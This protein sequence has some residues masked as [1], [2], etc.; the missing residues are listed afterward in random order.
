MFILLRDECINL[1]NCNNFL[2]KQA[3]LFEKNFEILRDV[4][5]LLAATSNINAIANLILDLAVN[6]TNAGKGS[7]MLVTDQG[8]LHILAARGINM[9]ILNSYRARLGDG[10]AGTVAQNRIPVL[11]EDIQVNDN[12]NSKKKGGYKSHSFI[13]C[14]ILR[15]NKVL[16]LFNVS[17]KQNNAPFTVD[18]FEL[19]KII[20]NQAAMSLENAF[21]LDRLQTK[22]ADLEEMN[23]KLI[24]TDALKTNFLV[25][26]SHE[27]RSPLNSINGAIYYLRSYYQTAESPPGDFYDIISDES[28]K[29]I[30]SVGNLLDCPGLE[31]ET[32]LT[33]KSVLDLPAMVSEVVNSTSLKE[34]L[35]KKNIGLEIDVQA[36]ISNIIGDKIKIVQFFTGMMD[37][38]SRYLEQD[39]FIRVT[40]GE[41]DF[42]KVNI[43]MSGRLPEMLIPNI[44]NWRYMFE[45]DKSEAAIKLYLALKIAEMHG[46]AIAEEN[47]E[48]AYS[49]TITMPQSARQKSEAVIDTAMGMF[50]DFI[51][52]LLGVDTCSIMLIDELAGDLVI[53][54]ARGLDDDI[55]KLTRLK[56]G[57][58][59]AGWVALQGEPLLVEDIENDSRFSGMSIHKYNTRSLLSIPLKINGRVIG[60]INLNNKRTAETFTSLDLSILSTLSD[61]ISHFIERLYSG[62]YRETEIQELVTSFNDLLPAV[63]KYLKKG[64]AFPDL[65]V[66][67]MNVLGAAEE[68]KRLALYAS[69]IYD[70]GLTVNE[71]LIEKKELSPPEMSVL[72]VHPHTSVDLIDDF[73][74]SEDVKEAIL[75]HH[76]KYDGTGYPG[77]LS[78]EEIPFISRVLSVV[79]AFCS[80]ITD[81]PYR[82]A[83]SKHTALQEIKRGAGSKYDPTV[84]KALDEVLQ[85]V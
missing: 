54:K 72:R 50:I 2:M 29:L 6:H 84:V 26:V 19:L 81:R 48:D 62:N 80:M 37:G 38:L 52:E 11:I 39:D 83:L 36:E 70:L 32:R 31:E 35:R 10:I 7:V 25:R 61:R 78:K 42:V 64:N 68:V 4:S 40:I 43:T 58:K 69:M 60:V 9:E 55:I 21:L 23:K 71:S 63:K 18:E 34:R 75:H 51:A 24:D 22:T 46:W 15:K 65:T 14:P 53:R 74:F 67:I 77:R 66:R 79:D 41:D 85:F 82:K 56:M 3:L 30:S 16:G 57:E 8:D 73:E 5:N 59:I 47:T 17:E 33:K 44:F 27:L 76:E 28:A 13:S 45:T 49:L 20:A 1:K 12:F